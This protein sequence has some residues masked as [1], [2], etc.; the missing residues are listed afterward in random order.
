MSKVRVELALGFYAKVALVAVDDGHL[1]VM[2]E[3]RQADDSVP[4][5]ATFAAAWTMEFGDRE[6]WTKSTDPLV[7]MLIGR[8]VEVKLP[9][10]E[11]EQV[12]VISVGFDSIVIESMSGTRGGVLRHDDVMIRAVEV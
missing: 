6:A 9:D 4:V 8:L 2:K 1:L 12:S 11:P 3:N 5:S 7:G 10:A